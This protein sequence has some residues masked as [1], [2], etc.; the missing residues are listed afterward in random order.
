VAGDAQLGSDA[1]RSAQG[2]EWGVEEQRDKWILKLF[3]L[4]QLGLSGRRR[5]VRR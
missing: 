4:K 1:K 3:V 5:P 2:R